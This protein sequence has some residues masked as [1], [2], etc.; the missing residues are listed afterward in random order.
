M[1]ELI[2]ALA[3]IALIGVYFYMF[4]FFRSNYIKSKQSGFVNKFF[5]GYGVFFLALFGFQIGLSIYSV[6]DIIDPS[7][8]NWIRESFPGSEIPGNVEKILFLENLILPLYILGLAGILILIGAQI[9]PIEETI[10]WK[11]TPGTK[12]L[13]IISGGLLLIF[14]PAI[15]WSY[16]SFIMVTSS[17]LGF[18]YG[19]ILNLAVNIKIAVA[20][21]GDLRKRSIS[22][23]FASFLFYLGFLYTLE[24][25]EISLEAITGLNIPMDWD[26]VLGC[27][28]QTLAALLYRQGLKITD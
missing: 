2:A 22:I 18:A 15:T 16:Y 17:I 6:L 28:L 3:R 27:V 12:I 21:T 13:F 7:L 14:I 24:I 5:I 23:I 4:Y 9:Y 19:L 10:G 11:R 26:T 20:S 1:E 25:Q 8:V